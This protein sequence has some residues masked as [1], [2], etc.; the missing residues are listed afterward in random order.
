VYEALSYVVLVFP[1]VHMLQGVTRVDA[2]A[3][4]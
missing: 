4:A 1:F 3:V 2:A